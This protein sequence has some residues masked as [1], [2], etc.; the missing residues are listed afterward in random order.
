ML[1]CTLGVMFSKVSATSRFYL[2][3]A[4]VVVVVEMTK[5]VT[6]AAGVSVRQR[7]KKKSVHKNLINTKV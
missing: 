2:F 7:T 6:A 3:A 1:F 5:K 4:F